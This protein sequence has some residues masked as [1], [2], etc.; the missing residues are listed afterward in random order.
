MLYSNTFQFYRLFSQLTKKGSEYFDFG[1]RWRACIW[2][3]TYPFSG[4][5]PALSVH[6]FPLTNWKKNVK[7]NHVAI[8]SNRIISIVRETVK[9][10]RNSSL[11]L[12]IFYL[13]IFRFI[14]LAKL[15]SMWYG[16]KIFFQNRMVKSAFPLVQMWLFKCN[17][18]KT[19]SQKRFLTR[20]QKYLFRKSF[21][22]ISITS[23]GI[24]RLEPLCYWLLS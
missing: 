16:W 1:I 3:K 13:Q 14:Y 12:F 11:I 22:F 9:V 17:H 2:H 15:L 4:T 21:M 23:L 7:K 18:A 8:L 10:E 6:L 19:G 20:W 5:V 24:K